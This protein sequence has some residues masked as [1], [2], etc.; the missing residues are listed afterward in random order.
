M[1]VDDEGN[2]WEKSNGKGIWGL[3]YAKLWA[4]GKIDSLNKA[5]QATWILLEGSR[6][7]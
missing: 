1:E 2:Q 3:V 7:I 4:K 6:Q 5:K